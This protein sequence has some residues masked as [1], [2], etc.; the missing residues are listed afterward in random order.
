VIKRSFED[1]LEYDSVDN[2]TQP[3][4]EGQEFLQ[5]YLEHLGLKHLSVYSWAISA[6][7]AYMKSL[8][9][10][11]TEGNGNGYTDASHGSKSK[12]FTQE[13]KYTWLAVHY[14]QGY[15]SDYLPL[16]GREYF[17]E[18]YMQIVNISNPAEFLKVMTHDEMQDIEDNWIV[19][20]P[21]APEM[22][23]PGTPDEQVKVAVESEPVI[24]FNNW[25]LFSDQDLQ[26]EGSH[27]EWLALFNYTNV[28]DSKSYISS[29]IDIRGVLIE[30]GQAPALLDI[31]ENYPQSSHFVESIYW[32]VSSPDTDSYSNP[33][34][35]V[36]M[37]WIG[38]INNSA[39]YYLPQDGE[40]KVMYYTVANVT[41]HTVEN[42]ETE[43][44]I[45]SKIIRDLLGITEMKQQ[46]F[47]DDTGRI[48][49]INHKLS[50]PNFDK[51]E[52]TLV[53]KREFLA[54]INAD[55]KEIVWFVNLYRAKN[56]L[57]ERIKSDEHPMKTRKYIVWYGNGGL[58]W[59][60]F[61]DARFSNQRDKDSN[62]QVVNGDD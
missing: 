12:L 59:K 17:V 46:L 44:Y 34:D 52:M 10:S 45:P 33:T 40:E 6:A 32:M 51:Q 27:L 50:H 28:H 18:D 30:R 58:H 3:E 14:I 62:Q 22:Q 37:N 23:E 61:W 31:V 35:V 48:M 13:E 7:I 4:N 11:R 56:P 2:D 16:K 9:F 5:A 25:I 49:S 43:I 42:G 21:L 53:P 8:G 57:N 47:F 39:T 29:S 1:F 54:K 55:G 19:K 41:K 38:E 36:W 24:D 15:L 60:K 26:C 20:E